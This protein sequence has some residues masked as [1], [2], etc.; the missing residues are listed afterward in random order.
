[1]QTIC[2]RLP[3]SEP[4][5]LANLIRPSFASAPEFPKK[6]FPPMAWSARNLATMGACSLMK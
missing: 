1:M 3:L 5:F 6:H 4:H 2:E